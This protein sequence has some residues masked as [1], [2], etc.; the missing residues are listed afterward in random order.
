MIAPAGRT[1][2]YGGGSRNFNSGEGFGS[3]GYG[4]IFDG[5]LD[6]NDLKLIAVPRSSLFYPRAAT[7]SN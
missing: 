4:K 1:S 6:C 7:S 2:G 5:I 3:E